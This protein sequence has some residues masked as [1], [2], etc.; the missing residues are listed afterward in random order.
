MRRAKAKAQTGGQIGETL[1]RCDH[2]VRS[3]KRGLAIFVEVASTPPL[4]G[5]EYPA[6][7]VSARS[8]PPLLRGKSY[9]WEFSASGSETD[10]RTPRQFHRR[11]LPRKYVRS[12]L[13]R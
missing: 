1:R 13:H 12:S 9:G 2:P 10:S 6:L 7:S 5:G 11:G 8:R 3:L 4:R